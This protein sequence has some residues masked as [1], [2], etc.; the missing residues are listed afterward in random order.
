MSHSIWRTATE[1]NVKKTTPL[2]YNW[3]G[4]GG[5]KGYFY[6][7]LPGRGNK[8]EEQKNKNREQTEGVGLLQ[9]FST[10]SPTPT[11]AAT[12]VPSLLLYLHIVKIIPTNLESSSAS[13]PSLK[14][15]FGCM[16]LTWKCLPLESKI[17]CTP[18]HK[19]LFWNN[20][21]A[22]F[23]CLFKGKA[24]SLLKHPH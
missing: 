16:R 5:R 15:K 24:S 23:F 13:I 6:L 10:E 12:A 7:G 8:E 18:K 14:V 2:I 21:Y 19:I 3:A 11:Q 9:T 1:N 22:I 4:G 17:D 20:C